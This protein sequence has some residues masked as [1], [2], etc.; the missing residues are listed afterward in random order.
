MMLE[1]QLVDSKAI[2][3]PSQRDLALYS[4]ELEGR[5]FLF[6]FILLNFNWEESAYCIPRPRSKGWDCYL[7]AWMDGWMV[8]VQDR[9]VVVDIILHPHQEQ[10]HDGII[11]LSSSAVVDVAPISAVTGVI[12]VAGPSQ[13]TSNIQKCIKYRNT[14]PTCRYCRQTRS[15][16]KNSKRNVATYIFVWTKT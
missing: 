6:C 2:A 1:S 8:C 7:H 14:P 10:W 11:V 12:A 15:N 4:L 9:I 5:T 16:S 3:P 13:P